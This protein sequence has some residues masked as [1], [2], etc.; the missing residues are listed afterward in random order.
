MLN[1]MFCAFQEM[2]GLAKPAAAAAQQQGRPP[3]PQEAAATCRYRGANL[4]LPDCLFNSK[5]CE[6]ELETFCQRA[7]TSKKHLTGDW[8]NHL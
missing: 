3:A 1:S 2:L 7:G 4:L 6:G 8:T 5:I